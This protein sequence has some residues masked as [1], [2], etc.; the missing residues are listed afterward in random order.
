QWPRAP[1]LRSLTAP[2]YRWERG[3]KAPGGILDTD[4]G[5]VAAHD[6]LEGSLRPGGP[7]PLD[8]GLYLVELLRAQ[9]QELADLGRLDPH[10][11][12]DALEIVR[13]DLQ[14]PAGCVQADGVERSRHGSILRMGY[15]PVAGMSHPEGIIQT[16]SIVNRCPVSFGGETPWSIQE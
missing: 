2:A 3:F 9:D 10:A 14:L 13:A 12:Q 8:P 4:V 1:A 7:D 16:C 6:P 11:V 5:E 15:R